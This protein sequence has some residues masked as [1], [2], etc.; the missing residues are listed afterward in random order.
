MCFILENAEVI[1][2]KNDIIMVL[3]ILLV[4]IYYIMFNYI[5]KNRNIKDILYKDL[6]VLIVNN[7]SDINEILLA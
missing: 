7:W 3:I 2:W 6:P 4:V 5:I 1:F